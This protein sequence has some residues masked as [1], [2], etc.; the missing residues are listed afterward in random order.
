MTSPV[1]ARRFAERA[2]EILGT[3]PCLLG[4]GPVRVASPEYVLSNWSVE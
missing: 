3:A 2:I 4:G 1:S